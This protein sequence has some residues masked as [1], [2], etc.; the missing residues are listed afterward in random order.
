MLRFRY[1][2]IC[3]KMH[4]SSWLVFTID[5]VKVSIVSIWQETFS[6]CPKTTCNYR[7]EKCQTYGM[8][9]ARAMQDETNGVLASGQRASNE[10]LIVRLFRFTTVTTCYHG[11][12]KWTG[13][14]FSGVLCNSTLI[15]KGG[16]RYVYRQ[17][18]E[19]P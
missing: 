5:A 15:Q 10:E 2:T 7:K 8:L 3:D 17:F 14:A 6:P 13:E 11:S 19:Q 1:T 18:S 9:L 16:T 4:Y 12:F